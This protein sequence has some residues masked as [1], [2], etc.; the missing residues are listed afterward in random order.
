MK[1]LLDSNIVIYA[2]IPEHVAVRRYLKD[3]EIHVSQITRVEVLG[4]SGLTP[5]QYNAYELLLADMIHHVVSSGVI[6]SAV[7]LRRQRK[8]SL[9]DALIAATALIHG[10]KLITRNVRDFQWIPGLS[11]V[12]PI[13]ERA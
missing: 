12:N 13:V 4:F 2:L 8:M 7:G 10:L 6:D 3:L 1:A 9:G 11:I 5:E